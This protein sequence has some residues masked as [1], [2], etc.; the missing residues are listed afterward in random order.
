MTRTVDP[1]RRI[2][3]WIANAARSSNETS[4]AV[5]WLN[6]TSV[7]RCL[8]AGVS[9]E[10]FDLVCVDGTLLQVILG[11]RSAPRTSAD[12]VLPQLLRMTGGH[13]VALVGATPSASDAAVAFIEKEILASGTLDVVADGY[14]EWPI[15]GA[16]GLA[17]AVLGLGAPLQDER[18]LELKAAG[19]VR[20]AMTCGG[21]IDQVSQPNYYPRWAYPL[22]LNWLVRLWREPARLWR[23]Y[24]IDAVVMIANARA[25]RRYVRSA[26]GFPA[27]SRIAEGLQV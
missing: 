9:L 15:P 23:R 11:A 6:H 8:R 7:M 1:S 19:G 18:A 17:L 27:A 5:T 2:A 4:V 16:E 13:G 12:L 14:S 20:V 21:W 24:T 3:E 25:V 10:A 26:P 22:K